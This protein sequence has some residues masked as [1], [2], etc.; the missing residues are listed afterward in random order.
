[1][2]LAVLP[3]NAAPGT[4]P[5]LARQLA[6][7]ACET[8]RTAAEADVQFVNF[9]AQVQTDQGPKGAFLNMAE[10]LLERE[11]LKQFFEQ[12]DAERVM[13]G[14]LDHIPGSDRF[15]MTVRFHDPEGDEPLEEFEF[16]FEKPDL[17]KS[18]HFLVKQVAKY[19][20]VALP[21]NLAG[22]TMEF[23]T[24]DPDAFLKFV[25][26]F[27]ALMYLNQTNGQVPPEF[28]PEGSLDA[29]LL[30]IH[31]DPD[32]LGAYDVLLQLSRTC[33]RF[34]IGRVQSIER[35]LQKAA[36]AHPTDFKAH[37]ALAEVY[38]AAS[39][40]NAAKEA[41]E[42]AIDLEDKEPALYAKLGML[43]H[44]LGMPNNAERSFRKAL[45]LEGPEKP[46]T[47]FLS[48]VLFQTNR[49]HEVPPMWKELMERFPDNAMY[50]AK[51]AVSLIQSGDEKGGVAAFEKGLELDENLWVKRA[52]APYLANHD[53]VDRALDFYEDCLEH[54]EGDIQL[55]F[56]YSQALQT[57]GREVDIPPVMRE[58]LEQ[59]QD[60]NVRAQAQAMLLEVEQKKRTELV[61]KARQKLEAGDLQGAVRDLKPLRNWLA[62]YWKIWHLLAAAHNQ[63]GE[64]AEAEYA[65]RRLIEL[66][67]GNEAGYIE[68]SNALGQL[69]KH[70][71]SYGAMRFA[72]ANL[73]VTVPLM[74]GLGFAAKR[75]GQDEE[76]RNIA[77]QLRE[78][79]GD[80]E[81]IRPVL[82]QMEA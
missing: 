73:Q 58:I 46:S 50:V 21:E 59:A 37:Y 27:D 53:D 15:E 68:L 11:W 61:E 36:A 79:L 14:L 25:E 19:A 71:E 74:I 35:A 17:F 48:M 77:K 1:M 63:L 67:P 40:P 26:G 10:T 45:E 72:V 31:K 32:F 81:N 41:V 12:T 5:S 9:L 39:N 38:E 22:E 62:D 64:A 4:P 66:F 76:A 78:A 65:A 20:D 8:V 57:A 49:G 82:E 28:D 29:L 18:L 80:D 75:F 16:A 55:K 44:Q 6:N 70:E 47:D 42:K 34:R 30:S 3:F 54:A 23:G 13:D 52:Y 51:Y 2:R 69:G 33:A 7:F 56:E 60:P 24:D 43:Q